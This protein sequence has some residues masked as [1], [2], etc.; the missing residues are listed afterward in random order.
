[1]LIAYNIL[2]SNALTSLH[3]NLTLMNKLLNNKYVTIFLIVALLGDMALPLKAFAGEGDCIQPQ[4]LQSW[5]SFLDPADASGPSGMLERFKEKAVLLSVIQAVRGLLT[6]QEIRPS[7]EGLRAFI[8]EEVPLSGPDTAFLRLDE[9]VR[10][11]NVYYLPFVPE[12]HAPAA[13]RFRVRGGAGSPRIVICNI[14][15]Y[16]RPGGGRADSE[17]FML[18]RPYRRRTRVRGSSFHHR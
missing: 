6:A 15:E 11:G 5:T 12:E 17:G 4:C 18:Q 7:S 14:V 8:R 13:L 9:I 10:R 16:K 3:N 2:T 1:M